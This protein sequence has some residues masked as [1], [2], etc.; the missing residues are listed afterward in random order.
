MD[1]DNGVDVILFL[2]NNHMCVPVLVLR[3]RSF[4]TQVTLLN[5]YLYTG[6]MNS[7]RMI[8]ENLSKGAILPLYN[9]V[10]NKTLDSMPNAFFIISLC[11]TI[12]L[13][14]CFM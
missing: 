6:S 9:I 14:G 12:P 11:L 3:T 2:D 8:L 7:V 5:L 13:I 1:W 4:K 10:Y